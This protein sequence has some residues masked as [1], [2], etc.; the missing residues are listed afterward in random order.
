MARRSLIRAIFAAVF[1]ASACSLSVAQDVLP[2]EQA[3]PYTVEADASRLVVKFAVLDGYYLYRERFGFDTATPGVELGTAQFPVGEI[4]SDEFFGEQETYRRKFEIALPYRRTA[5]VE[6]VQLAIRLQG[7]ADIGL[8]Y[9]PQDWTSAVRIPAGAPVSAEPRTAS[10]L[11]AAST[12]DLLPAEQAFVMN[13]RFDRPNELTVGWQIAPGYYLYRDKLS[14]RLTGEIELGRAALPAGVAHRDDNFGDVEV[15]YDYVEAVIPF[16]RAS[17]EEI[18]VT[19]TAGFQGCKQDSICYPPGEQVM[20]LVLPATS[21]FATSASGPERESGS[22]VVSEQDRFSNVILNGSLWT[23]LGV[24]YVA[25]LALS[26]TPCVL[27]M[28]PILSSIIAGQGGT[29]SA[30]RGFS[31]S[32]SYVLGMAVTYTSAGALAALAGGQIQAMFQKPWIITVFAALFALLALGMFGLYE[33]QMP[34]AVQTRLANLA[35]RQKGGTYVGTAVMGALTAL[36][37]T[38]CVAP[39]LV[40]A[41]AVIGQTGDVGRGAAALFALSLGMGSPLLIVGA[42]AG[43]ILPKVG[44]W[45]NTVKAA[46]GVMMLGLAIWMMERVLP[47]SVTLVLWSL[48]VFM[49]GVF[50]GALD[51][52]PQNATSAKRLSKGLGLLACLYGALLLIGAVLGG[53]NPLKPFPQAARGALGGGALA[54]Q[55]RTLTF[56]PVE[57]VAELETALAEA[58]AAGQAVMLDFTAD[59]CVSC[60]EMEEYTFPDAGVVAALEPAMLLR[61]D[62]TDNNDDDKA[63]L[64]YFRSF[65]PPTIAF[66][67]ESGREQESFKLVGFVPAA[68]FVAHVERLLAL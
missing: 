60:R 13:A 58:R 12:D 36:I 16:A 10:L 40:G 57:T 59:W 62:V 45:M 66:F 43:Q 49:S 55:Q 34:A 19:L 41:L 33:L 27:P 28:V 65:G 26:L 15:F 14:F 56:R 35:N 61:A 51:P 11:G 18:E 9:P 68:D 3:F 29:V 64:K 53:D 17:P 54:A 63:L 20:A 48:L 25:G 67:D 46:F 52:L 42:S 39:P 50:L 38:T 44:P 6:E 5:A 24:F 32:A 22:P 31:L 2:P 8:C 21:E 23:L 7:C 1:G 4:H 47:G 30:A 37:V